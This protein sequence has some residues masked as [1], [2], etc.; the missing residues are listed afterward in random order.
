[1]TAIQTTKKKP[2]QIR[3]LKHLQ[4]AQPEYYKLLRI[5]STDGG[6]TSSKGIENLMYWYVCFF[7]LDEK[8]T[9]HEDDG[10]HTLYSTFFFREKINRNNISTGAEL[11]RLILTGKLYNQDTA[12]YAVDLAR[13]I[14]Q[15]WMRNKDQDSEALQ[16]K[17]TAAA[18][19]LRENFGYY[20]YNQHEAKL[21]ILEQFFNTELQA[22]LPEKPKELKRHNKAVKFLQDLR[23]IQRKKGTDHWINYAEALEEYAYYLQEILDGY[24]HSDEPIYKTFEQYRKDQNNEEENAKYWATIEEQE[25]QYRAQ[26]VN[27]SNVNRPLEETTDDTY[28]SNI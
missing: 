1:M 11:G 14:V 13:Y 2:R 9:A 25:K 28:K 10:L 27:D 23:E 12:E 5:C 24:A 8:Q 17:Y 7:T 22:L 21:Y 19:H 18:K 16:Q 20:F 3:L 26:I 6:A 4:R 15:S